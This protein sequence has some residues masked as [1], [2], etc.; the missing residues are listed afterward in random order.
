MRKLIRILAGA[1]IM[2]AVISPSAAYANHDDDTRP[3]GTSGNVPPD[4]G[5]EGSTTEGWHEEMPDLAVSGPGDV[6]FVTG[7]V[8]PG[9]TTVNPAHLINIP[10]VNANPSHSHF[11]FHDSLITCPLPGSVGD[12]SI[13]A[14][15]G[16]DGHMLDIL[17][18]TDGA[19][20]PVPELLQPCGPNGL[21][22]EADPVTQPKKVA[23][24]DFNRHHGSVNESAWSHSS[25]YSNDGAV[26]YPT[27]SSNDCVGGDN[28]LD[29]NKGDIDVLAPD[30]A[31]GW[32]KYIRVGV[33]VHT[34]GCFFDG[35]IPG[36]LDVFS[37]ELLILPDFVPEQVGQFFPGGGSPLCVTDGQP[38]DLGDPCGF[39]LFGVALR[40]TDWLI[41]C[42]EDPGLAACV[43]GILP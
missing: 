2:A 37:A 1:I 28:D 3:A 38:V 26:S 12:I 36:D 32:V 27:G 13:L 18:K 9:D 33:V 34:W 22:L 41:D 35:T 23:E 24:H 20:D 10:L 14:D 19:T 4:T 21:C 31:D 43:T 39:V 29:R 5:T 25:E 6:C 8:E 17:H 42:Q 16:N 40:G 11:I 7:Q 15:G 30:T